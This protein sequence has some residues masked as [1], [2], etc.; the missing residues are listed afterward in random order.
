[1]CTG[2]QHGF[3]CLHANF[4]PSFYFLN[5]CACGFSMYASVLSQCCPFS[6]LS[7][8]SFSARLSLGQ[9]WYLILIPIDPWERCINISIHCMDRQGRRFFC[10][11][12][13][14]IISSPIS[15]LMV[16][17]APTVYHWSSMLFSSLLFI[18]QS[19][20]YPRNVPENPARK[21]VEKEVCIKVDTNESWVGKKQNK[22]KTKLFKTVGRSSTILK[23]N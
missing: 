12:M 6:S 17:H 19:K 14:H 16:L 21:F 18:F 10:A 7:L 22:T 20:E 23:E 5:L 1:M 15:K 3:F 13:I 9:S 11:Q 2:S 8:D 4:F